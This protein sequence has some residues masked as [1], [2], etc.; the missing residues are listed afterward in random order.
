MGGTEFPFVATFYSTAVVVGTFWVP[1]ILE[2]VQIRVLIAVERATALHRAA[3]QLVR[4]H[5]IAARDGICVWQ[6]PQPLFRS[7]IKRAAVHRRLW[8]RFTTLWFGAIDVITELIRSAGHSLHA[9]ATPIVPAVV[10]RRRYGSR[11]R[12][13]GHWSRSNTGHT[14]L[15]IIITR[16]MSTIRRASAVPLWAANTGKLAMHTGHPHGIDGAT[17]DGNIVGWAVGK[18]RGQIGRGTDNFIMHGILVGAVITSPSKHSAAIVG[19]E[20]FN[21]VHHG[22]R[23]ICYQLFAIRVLI[24]VI[25]GCNTVRVQRIIITPRDLAT[26][27][28]ASS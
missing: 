6:L 15:D 18:P 9:I 10:A 28:G 3:T 11:D 17:S 27:V 13:R 21:L 12:R 4:A 25:I 8:Q 23:H 1:T 20:R 7:T 26:I 24:P 22:P 2:G 16:A 5:T 14:T 19:F